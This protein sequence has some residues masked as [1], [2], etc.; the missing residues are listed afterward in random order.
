[1][2]YDPDPFVPDP[3]DS[4]ESHRAEV[5]IAALTLLVE[6]V[7]TG[8]LDEDVYFA[9]ARSGFSDLRPETGRHWLWRV[10]HR[11]NEVWKCLGR[12]N[13]SVMAYTAWRER[14]LSTPPAQRLDR[15]GHP[16]KVTF[17]KRESGEGGLRHEHV[18]PMGLML[19]AMLDGKVTPEE[20]INLNQD[21]II[22]VGEDRHLDKS[23]HPNLRDPWARYAN[24]GIKFIPNPAWSS[25]HRATLE[26]HG[27]VAL[28]AEL[29]AWQHAKDIAT[30]PPVAV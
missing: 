22:T 1:M 3:F 21:A 13:W 10:H 26:R 5:A 30:A 11:H 9:R 24:S 14:Y 20:A 4:P 12:P 25:E 28:G 6:Q 27:L 15:H 16:R 2:S 29:G 8:Q 7:R 19:Q 17:P 18:V 23:G